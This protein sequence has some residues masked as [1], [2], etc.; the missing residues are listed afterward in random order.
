MTAVHRHPTL[1]LAAFGLLLAAIYAAELLLVGPRLRFLARSRLHGH[2]Q[3]LTWADAP[4][5]GLLSEA[6]TGQ[7]WTKN[8]GW[9]VPLVSLVQERRPCS[10]AS[11]LAA[12]C[13]GISV[14]DSRSAVVAL[15][16]RTARKPVHLGTSQ[17]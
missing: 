16:S 3:T 7:G 8:A 10:R 1:H 5:V 2:E 14:G 13:Y 11:S 4:G 9:A 12:R 15:W 6:M 17:R